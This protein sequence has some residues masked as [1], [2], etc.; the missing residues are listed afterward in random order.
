MT[1]RSVPLL[2]RVTDAFFALDTDFRF[3]YLNER[4]ET[5]LKRSRVDLIGRVMWDEFPTTVETQFPDRFHRAMDEQVPVSFEIYH[6]HLETWFEARAYPAEDGLSVYMRDV[7]ARKTQET[8]LAQHAAVVEA[9][10]DAV[11]TLDRDRNLVTVNGATEAL[12][13][14]DRSNLVGKHIEFLTKRAGIGDEHAIQIGQAITDV[15]VGN[16]VDRHLELPFTDADGTDRIGEFR[17]VPIEDDV[18][19][20]AAVIRDVTDRREY[21]RVVTSLHE[22]TRWL[23]ESDDPEEICAIAV[24]AGSDLLNLPIS[25]VWLLDDEHGYLDPVAGTAGAHDEFGGLPRFSPGEGLVWDVFESGDVERFDDLTTVDDL[26]NPDT[27]IRSEIIAPI[28]TH[29]VIMTGSF[30][31]HQ[32]DETDVDLVSTLVENTHAAL[33]RAQR[34]QVLRERTAEL[35]RQTDRLESVADVLSSD[36]KQQLSTLA[37]ALSGEKTPHDAA[38]KFPLAEDTV[39]TTLERTERLVD[40]VR[41]F[42]R[43]AAAVGP[44]TRIDLESAITDALERSRLQSERVVVEHSASLRADADRFVRLLETAFDDTAARATDGVTIQVGLLGVDNDDRTRGF[45]LLDDAAEI[46]ALADERVLEPTMHERDGDG[47]ETNP[48]SIADDVDGG[49]ATGESSV[50]SDMSENTDGLGLA[51]VRAIAEAHDWTLTVDTG[52][53]GGTRLEIT[54]VTT[55]E[56]TSDSDRD[57]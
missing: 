47:R 33:E 3:T 32:F 44:R 11:L 19:T 36:L 23:L 12:L 18:A 15:D 31:A 20:V 51:L 2:D 21:E 10:H 53:N 22:I 27:P 40:D 17:F 35:E 30:E 4:A 56:E 28:G 38:W 29:G 42:A 37:D 39:Q 49:S 50:R 1:G 43:N 5:L 14:I 45:F 25:G 46:P 16:A 41:E 52:T 8:T 57:L 9:V 55:L 13:G 6:A 24:H 48:L 54:D 34:E 7:T 26:Y